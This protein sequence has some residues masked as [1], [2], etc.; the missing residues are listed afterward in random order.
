MTICSR[1]ALRAASV[2]FCLGSIA[3]P[4][5]AAGCWTQ[6]EVAA[7]KVREM[8][9]KLMVAVLQCRGSGIDMLPSYNRFLS[10]GRSALRS[11]NEHLKAHFIAKGKIVGQREYDRYTTVLANAYGGGQISL[12]SCAATSDLVTEAAMAK[13][14][15]TSLAARE[16]LV[17]TLPSRPCRAD[18]AMVLAAK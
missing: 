1:A 17:P 3:A 11:A 16:V 9:T 12:D 5:A 10:N 4:A 7:A 13:S 18:N 8:Q 14:D 15:L 2:A 6:A